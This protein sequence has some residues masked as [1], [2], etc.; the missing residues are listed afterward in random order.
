MLLFIALFVA[1]L[2]AFL[3]AAVLLVPG[4]GAAPPAVAEGLPPALIAQ[5]TIALL[6]ALVASWVMLRFVDRRPRDAL[7]FPLGRSVPLELAAGVLAGAVAVGAVVGM[8]ALVGV[9]RYVPEPGSVAGWL[10]VAGASLAAF[11]IPAAAEEA[12]F[13]GYALRALAEGPGPLAAVLLTSVAFALLHGG[14]PAVAPLA[15]LNI[16]LAG[17]VLAVA[18]LRT[19]TLWFATAVHLGWNWM[20]AG[21]LDLPVSGLE[22]YDPPLYDAVPAPPGWLSG[23]AFGPEGGLAG[24][25]AACAALGLVVWLTQPGRLHR[26]HVSTGE[27]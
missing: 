25:V 23:G 26:P 8:L 12:I 18:V 11:A 6:A 5:F 9:Y 10:A 19:G 7:G 2:L 3:S 16:F 24:T 15:L 27:V 14:N 4:L 21:P 20:M 13:R 22:A 17:I 1:T